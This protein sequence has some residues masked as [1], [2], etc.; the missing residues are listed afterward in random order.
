MIPAKTQYKT[1]DDELLAIVEAFKV[2]QYYLKDCKHKVLMLTNDNNLCYFMEIK[3]LSSCQVWWAQK[4]RQQGLQDGLYQDINRVLQYQGLS[5][6]PKAIRMEL[7]SRHHNN[8]LAGHFGI[9]KTR[10]LLVQK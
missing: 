3:C 7:I 10:K 8:C 1:H 5:F 2:W 6:V 4:L 9:K